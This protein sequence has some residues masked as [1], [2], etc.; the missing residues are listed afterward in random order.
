MTKRKSANTTFT[1]QTI[2]TLLVLGGCMPDR[3]SYQPPESLPGLADMASGEDI[4]AA[5]L[6]P[7]GGQSSVLKETSKITPYYRAHEVSVSGTTAAM[8]YYA[9]TAVYIFDRVGTTWNLTEKITGP[10]D[11]M[12]GYSVVLDGDNLYVGARGGG[13]ASIYKRS[14]GKWTEAQKLRPTDLSPSNDYGV[15]LAVDGRTLVVTDHS[16]GQIKGGAA[17]VYVESAGQWELQQKLT[18]TDGR[19]NDSV[20]NAVAISGDTI[21]VGAQIPSPSDTI[22]GAAYV[23]VRDNNK[24][25]QQQ[26]LSAPDVVAGTADAFGGSVGVSGDVALIGAYWANPNKSGALY[27]FKRSG[28]TWSYQKKLMAPGMPANAQFSYPLSVRGRYA[29]VGGTKV[30]RDAD[31]SHVGSVSLFSIENLSI[32]Q[33]LSPSDPSTGGFGQARGVSL[34][35]DQAII[36]GSS[37]AVAAYGYSFD[38]SCQ[39]VIQ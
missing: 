28:A 26:K 38:G 15:S 7:D 1:G 6:C 14:A 25:T 33:T 21:V 4:A 24:W 32:V 2:F 34:A 29:L 37:P 30:P 23:F 22:P 20:G 10:A 27:A 16:S 13:F 3:I 35:S 18:A 5:P 11:S 12:F 19:Q 9:D 17:Y 39:T 36:L 31:P 8:G